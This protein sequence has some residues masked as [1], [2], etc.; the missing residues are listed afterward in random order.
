MKK[1]DNSQ[2][3]WSE[4]Y[5]PQTIDDVVVTKEVRDKFRNY[6]RDER[7]PHILLSSTAPGLGKTSITNA[8]IKDLEAD[9][10][11]INGSSDRGISTF[12]E[13]VRD[14]VLS[15]AID[16]SPKIV[17]IDEADGLTKEAQKILRGLIE[18]FSKQSTFILTCN[19]K[20][21]LIEPLRNRFIHF[22]FDNIYNQNKKEIGMQ[23]FERLQFI[24]NNEGVEFEKNTLSPVIS[25]LYP[26]FRKMVLT[27]QQS[28]ENGK[29]E[30][31]E[32]MININTRY[33][34]ILE[35]V[36]NKK[37]IELR[38]VLQNLDDPGSFY[39]FVFKHL[40]EWFKPQSQPHVILLCA[41]YQDMDE[42]ARD[43]SITSTAFC[44][45]LMG[46]SSIEFV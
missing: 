2:F 41:K 43:K 16:D 42:R 11:W 38:K 23:M 1:V 14:F 39:T 12:R 31:N 20:E 8:V 45:E 10:K 37:F 22:D 5:R 40:D 26:S 4:K 24:L 17:V 19:Y 3:I 35:N 18:E 33:G 25:N 44:V 34:E 21:Q 36:K 13:S 9:V 15:V 7:F 32:S 29:L 6:I 30:L 28:V 27:L 46:T